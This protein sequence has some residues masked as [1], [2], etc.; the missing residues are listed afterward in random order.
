MSFHYS[1]EG[2]KL[3]ASQSTKV[4]EVINQLIRKKGLFWLTISEFL[5]RPVPLGPVVKQHIL[6]RSKATHLVIVRNCKKQEVAGS[7]QPL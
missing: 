3:A 5:L 4:P 6:K 2:G 7:Q 1:G